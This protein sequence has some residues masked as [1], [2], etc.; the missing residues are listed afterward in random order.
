MF[1]GRAFSL[2][3]AAGW[4]ESESVEG[5]L[6]FE[7]GDSDGLKSSLVSMQWLHSFNLMYIFRPLLHT[8]YEIWRI[9]SNIFWLLVHGCGSRAGGTYGVVIE[10]RERCDSA[11]DFHTAGPFIVIG[12]GTVITRSA[13]TTLQPRPCN[14]VVR[15][16][17]LKLVVTI[18]EVDQAP[19]ALHP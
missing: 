19:Q 6:G 11:L 18:K 17:L 3:F 15:Q 7:A 1:G 9:L 16:Y 8:M 5:G 12:Q 10:S 2:S 4:A 14:A 13:S